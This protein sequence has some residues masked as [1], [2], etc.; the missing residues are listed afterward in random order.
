[1]VRLSGWPE[2]TPPG[3]KDFLGKRGHWI[4]EMAS[5]LLRMEWRV[6][7]SSREGVIAPDKIDR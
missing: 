4:D 5:D 2:N 7:P 3:T 6:N 1:M